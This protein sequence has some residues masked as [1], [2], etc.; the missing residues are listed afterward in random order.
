MR[1]SLFEIPEEPTKIGQ[2][3]EFPEGFHGWQ[4]DGGS[5]SGSAEAASGVQQ[6]S[7]VLRYDGRILGNASASRGA[8]NGS[9][10]SGGGRITCDFAI[11]G[12]THRLTGSGNI[13]VHGRAL[14]GLKN[15]GRL[16]DR[17]HQLR[18]AL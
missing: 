5:A 7:N 4:V 18:G 15:I 12:G 9:F 10:G 1:R 14:G 2:V 8:P 16:T 11:A 3:I 6:L 17:P 13:S